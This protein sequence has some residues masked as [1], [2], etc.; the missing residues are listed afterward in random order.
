MGQGY[1]SDNQGPG[2]G[3]KLD[4]T[5]QYKIQ[6]EIDVGAV[7]K[8]AQ[9]AGEKIKEIYDIKDVESWDVEVKSDN[10]PLTRADKEANAV[11]C[12]GLEWLTPHIPITSEENKSVSYGI[13]QK[14]QYNWCVDPLDGTKEFIKRNGQFTVNIALIERGEPVLGVVHT[15]I[16]GTTHWAA[17]GH[18]AFVRFEGQDKPISCTEYDPDQEGLWVVASASHMNQSTEQFISQFKD[19]QFRQLGSSLKLLL[20]AEGLANVY[21][22]LAPTCEW[23][24]AAAHV[25]VTEAGGVVLQAGLC[26][27]KGNPLE[28]WKEALAKKKPL[29]YNKEDSLN[30]FFVVYGKEK[31]EKEQEQT[32][33][34]GEEPQSEQIDDKKQLQQ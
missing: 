31:S 14:Y 26:D 8:I 23:D 12:K 6:D 33:A 34:K 16:A 18:G 7:I 3:Y 21:P 22:R 30:P 29:V 19:P 24:T 2:L 1:S 13:R 10:S 11:I 28:D 5:I 15:P 9:D 20:V 32:G 17:K 27:N 4:K 25:I